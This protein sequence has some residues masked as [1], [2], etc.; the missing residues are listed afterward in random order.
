MSNFGSV[1]VRFAPSPTGELHLGGARTALFN[2]LYAK[3]HQGSFFLRIEDTDKARSKDVFTG[4]ILDS[5]KWLG[6]DWD[7]PLIY[8]SGRA[9]RYKH[10]MKELLDDGKAYRCF[11][12]KSDL[13]NFKKDGYAFYPG[14]CRNL[15]RENPSLYAL[16]LKKVILNLMTLFMVLSKSIIRN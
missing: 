3:K 10:Y 5:L 16:N 9:E 14:T 1:K 6:L 4:Q 11:C 2:W 15:T 12:S 8:Q 13:K 7:G